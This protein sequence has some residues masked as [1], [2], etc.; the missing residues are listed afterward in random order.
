MPRPAKHILYYIVAIICFCSCKKNINL[1][2]EQAGDN[3]TELEKVLTHFDS[4]KDMLKYEAAVYLIE[5]MAYHYTYK[6]DHADAIDSAYNVMSEAALEKR[7]S[8]FKACT[9]GKD[10]HS[11]KFIIDLKTVKADYLIKMIDDAC[12]TWRNSGWCE[13]YDKE[14]FF[15]YVLPYRLLNEQVS[16]WRKEINGVFPYLK[17][18][19]VRSKRG[20]QLEAEDA[21][22]Q[23]CQLI[24]KAS[25]SKSSA[26]LLKHGG[27]VVTYKIAST[28]NA[29]KRLNIRCSSPTKGCKV[30]II[31]NGLPI[32]TIDIEP[33]ISEDVFKT[34]RQGVD[35]ALKKGM[36]NISISNV[37]GNILLDYVQF[38]SVEPISIADKVL[39]DDVYCQ[40]RNA[41]T[42]KCIVFDT[43]RA[44][45]L[46]VMEVQKPS[47]NDSS[48][49]LRLDYR[50]NASWS[51]SSFKHDSIDL[52]MEVKYCHTFQGAPVGQYKYINGNNQKWVLIPA[53]GSSY[54][55]MNKDSGLYLDFRHDYS[56]NRD[57]LM[58]S[59]YMDRSS[60]KWHL[61]KKGARSVHASDCEW[62][63]AVDA[64]F[65]IYDITHEFEWMGYDSQLPPKAS[66]LCRGRTGN[67]R[68]ES[69]FTVYL[70]RSMGI[71][72]AVDFTPHWGNRSSSHAWSVI[73]KPDGSSTPFY[74]GCTPG[75]T[76]HYFHGYKKPKVFRHRFRLNKEYACDLSKEE[77][78]PALF[79]APDFID[80]T[81]EYYPNAKAIVRPIPEQYKERKVAYICV[82][83][84]REWVPVFYGNISRGMT[85]FRDMAP[86][87]MYMAAFYEGNK[88]VPF[89]NPFY[90][91]QDGTLVEVKAHKAKKQTVKLL[92]KYPFMGKEDYFNL[93]MNEGRFQGANKQDFS[94]AETFYQYKGIP[95]GNWIKVAT[96]PTK[97]YRY[98]R[99]IG[100]LASYCNINELEFYSNEG[101]KLA[102]KII[103]TD[104]T[105]GCTK[106]KVF[107]GDILTGFNGNS[108]DGHWVG[109]A[110]SR[111]ASVSTIRFIP[112][113]DGNG[114]EI[115][116][117]YALYVWQSVQWK[118]VH[119]EIASKN[120]LTIQNVPQGALYVLRN[121]SKGHEER[122]FTYEHGKQIW[123]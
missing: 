80:V 84:N 25:A 10:A 42:G 39:F 6:G 96:K 121:L 19:E 74:M 85:T 48:S 106:E 98:L 64:A 123:W 50:G 111:P 67:C 65:K 105:E 21:D 44:S 26:V 23:S 20:E 30:A 102:G 53:G 36:N 110:L 40:I 108:P 46:N 122:I 62:G 28:S 113:N 99:Y 82:F 92:R 4:N 3:R 119:T 78:V 69:A 109:L 63:S 86:D 112:R 89:G 91:Q 118:C 1:A 47:P 18:K 57:T 81:K 43:L 49:Y 72:S 115:G 93:R 87:V 9:M 100:P 22:F 29:R 54:R 55:I 14:I 27:D 5:N 95:E 94:D 45:L 13:Q 75:D 7:D 38:V 114:I 120:M 73:I 107:D 117:T 97:Q 16:D 103:G 90:L 66:S 79:N 104:G 68:D 58:Q 76:V 37:S 41:A 33:T 56:A 34:Q 17:A 11:D 15:D 61:E 77:C 32:D 51:I 8:I 70:C 60:Q 31:Q 83:D 35:I 12:D 2:L 52:C 101:N 59:R 116:D 88:V 71:P 24:E